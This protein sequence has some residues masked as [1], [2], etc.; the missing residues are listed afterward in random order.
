[1]LESHSLQY[2]V[3]GIGLLQS[4]ADI[5]DVVLKSEKG[6][7]IL[8]SDVAAIRS[9][10]AA[11]QGASFKDGKEEAVGG[12]VMMLRGSNSREVVQQIDELVGQDQ[13]GKGSASRL[14]DPALL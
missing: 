8:V 13:Q 1:M 6:I 3:R 12:I 2:I 14:E 4:V 11:R 7:P 5:G 10:H 9:G